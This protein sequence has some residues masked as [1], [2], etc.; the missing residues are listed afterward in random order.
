MTG[1]EV[2]AW[3]DRP[4]LPAHAE[5]A[6][7]AYLAVWLCSTDPGEESST[8]SDDELAHSL[9]AIEATGFDIH[10]DDLDAS[11]DLVTVAVRR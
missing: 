1:P 2:R 3:R 10:G 11:L 4:V 5:G 6:V 9:A 8:G 7:L